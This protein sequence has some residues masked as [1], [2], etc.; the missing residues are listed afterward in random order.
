MLSRHRT[1]SA[2]HVHSVAPSTKEETV[3]HITLHVRGCGIKGHWKVV[4]RNSRSNDHHHDKR[5]HYQERTRSQH[6]SDP[7]QTHPR[8]RSERRNR[9]RV[10]AI[11]D[12]YDDYDEAEQTFDTIHV[13]VCDAIS[14]TRREVFTTIPI[15]PPNTTSTKLKIKLKID[16][17]A[18]GNTLPMRTMEQIY[19]TDEKIQNVLTQENVKLTAY[20]G[21]EIK[22]CRYNTYATLRQ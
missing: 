9:Q 8:E 15:K 22:Y 14:S 17:G 3:L 11:S 10:E 6:R 16:T 19:N 18:S 2:D 5:R 21:K 1:R 7:R 13:Q 20:N 4:C 12:D